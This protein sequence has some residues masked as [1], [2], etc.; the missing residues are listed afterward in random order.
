MAFL[1]PDGRRP[2]MLY[3]SLPAT[4]MDVSASWSLAAG[5]GG[6]GGAGDVV[7][8]LALAVHFMHHLYRFP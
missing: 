8:V 4:P 2:P 5:H 1:R 3:S 6:R 7:L